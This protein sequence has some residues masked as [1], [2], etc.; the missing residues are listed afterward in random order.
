MGIATDVIYIVIAALI[1][2]TLA[3]VLRQPLACGYIVAGL[4]VGPYTGGYTVQNTHEIEKLAEIGVALLLFTLGLEFSFGEL[5]RLARI[6]LLATPLQ[7][8]LC[9]LAGYSIAL[10]AGIGVTDALWIGGAISL[11]STMVVLKTLSARDSLGTREGRIMLGILIAQDLAVVPLMLVLPQLSGEHVDYR[12][13]GAALVKSAAFLAVMYVAGTRLLP[14]IFTEI[15]NQGSRELFFL[16]T[17]GFAFGAGF[18]SHQMEL[19]FALGAFVAGML[20]SETDFHHQALSDVSHLRDLF[21]VIFFVSVGM[22]F[23][24]MFFVDHIGMVAVLVGALLLAKAC[25]IGLIVALFGYGI[26]AA[27]SVGL[28]LAQVGEFA[29]V[30]V[31]VGRSAGDFSGESYSLMIAVTVVSMV[32][33]PALFALGARVRRL[34]EVGGSQTPIAWDLRQ[35]FGRDHV[36]II[37]AGVVGRYVSR[38]L[39][40]L[41]RPYIVVESDYKVALQL[42][43]SHVPVVFGDATRRAILDA[44]GVAQCA[45]VVITSTNDQILPGI[46]TEV[47]RIR[48]DLPVV[49]RVEE[50]EDIQTLSSLSVEEIVQPQFEVGL[51]MVR[52]AL[53]ALKTDEA[54]I[55][56]LLGQLRA[57]RYE[58]SSFAGM[59]AAMTDEGRRRLDASRLLELLWL[60]VSESS[61]LAGLSLQGAK[62]RERFSV[63]VVGIMRQEEFIPSPSA[64]TVMQPGDVLAVLGTQ[65]QFGLIRSVL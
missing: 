48:Q 5:R 20:L 31:N 60:E 14:R 18:L 33:T 35:E 15:A 62:L 12:A 49:V 50:V 36:V 51:E 2:G 39:S 27:L 65:S 54:Q 24:P 16:S 59:T 32:L 17:L 10:V 3:H 52:Q 29:F 43:D 40:S 47:K 8:L 13:I 57:D 53:L 1:G 30:I 19:S 28:G 42:R 37:G 34:V 38:V 41:E 23:D 56:T 45:L 21:A 25:I 11:S 22:L 61:E 64:N 55:F 46:I 6:T 9:A 44:A 7:I 26:P 4:L 58:T 63:S